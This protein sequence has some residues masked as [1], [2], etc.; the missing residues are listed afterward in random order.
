MTQLAQLWR[1]RFGQLLNEV[2]KYGRL[3]FNDHFSII[4]FVIL[5]F[6]GLFYRDQLI[7]LQNL[8]ATLIR[9]PIILFSVFILG[10][11]FQ[12]GRP[13]LLTKDPDKSY[14]FAQGKE[15]HN[16]WLRGTLLGL[17]LPVL[18]LIGATA[19][20]MPFIQLV[21]LWQVTHLI[22]LVLIVIA[23]KVLSFLLLYLNIFDL[24]LGRI[25]QPFNQWH[26]TAIFCGV[27]LLSFMMT[28]S[29][30]HLVIPISVVGLLVFYVVW[31]L[32]QRQQRP[33]Q[34]QYVLDQEAI[35]ESTFYKWVAIFAD[36]PHLV[37]SVKRRAYLD[38]LVG[39]IS[40][41]LLNRYSFVYLRLLFR[42]NA[43][44]G[45]WLR[46][47]SFIALL[48]LMVDQVYFA[49]GLG[50]VGYVLTI[51]QLV[52]L[53]HYY[54]AHPL[55]RLYPNRDAS[56]VKAFQQ[57]MLV[58]FTIQTIVFS[59]AWGIVESV[60]LNLLLAVSVW[61]IIILIIIYLY[62]PMWNR[63]QATTY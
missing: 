27:M 4:L 16:Y 22:F 11:C 38:P 55:Q 10:I 56:K 29:P 33:I 13:I 6:A 19:L 35:R 45:V 37:P 59:V 23:L 28:T 48:L 9:L 12:V 20:L 14:L 57:T 46:V 17:S 26:H 1:K 34:F 52:P 53:I 15:W 18:L 7:Q 43:F 47:M 31:A 54:D 44:S 8:D 63:K 5:G 3:I 51:V 30:W 40:Q 39:W 41:R 50:I 32:S 62:I 61:I 58:I 25:Q 36:V 60:N 21:T 49:I 2:G 24:G 42:N